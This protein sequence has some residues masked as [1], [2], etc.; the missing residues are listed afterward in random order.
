MG[1]LGHAYELFTMESSSFSHLVSLLRFYRSLDNNTGNF[2]PFGGGE[3]SLSCSSRNC[4]GETEL[5]CQIDISGHF[6][7]SAT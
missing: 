4:V 5:S 2:F 6:R 1:I 7:S 3:E